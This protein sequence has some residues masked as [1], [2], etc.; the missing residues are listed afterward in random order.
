VEVLLRVE[1]EVVVLLTL[2]EEL[3]LHTVLPSLQ[4]LPDLELL[5]SQIV[6]YVDVP[7]KKVFGHRML[8]F[9]FINPTGQLTN[10]PPPKSIYHF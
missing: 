1:V 7:L 3:L 9:Y 4:V 2:I 8:Y 10:S 6:H 5:G